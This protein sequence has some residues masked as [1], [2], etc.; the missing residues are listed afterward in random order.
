MKRARWGIL[1][2][3]IPVLLLVGHQQTLSLA[4]SGFTKQSFK[5][6][7]AVGFSGADLNV[8]PI[9]G[10][11]IM[12][13]DGNGNLTGTQTIK[14][15]PFVCTES[16][17]GTYSINADGTGA[18]TVTVTSTPDPGVC[19]ASIGNVITFSLVLSG[20][21]AG[22]QVKLSETNPNYVILATGDRQ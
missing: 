7:Y 6:R 15:G 20:N 3:I 18:G 2:A 19:A 12:V 21:G 14:D 1:A 16:F 8:G 22:S 5:G 4:D 17:I 13:S 11:G 10:T 9:A